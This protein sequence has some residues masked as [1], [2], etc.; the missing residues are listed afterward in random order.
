MKVWK[1]CCLERKRLLMPLT[2]EILME[3][4]K[5]LINRVVA[6]LL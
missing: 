6:C 5:Q 1:K 4:G 3:R 2:T